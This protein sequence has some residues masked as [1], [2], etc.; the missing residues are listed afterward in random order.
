MSKI[1]NM[2]RPAWLIA[3]V[4]ITV[5]LVPAVAV[6][7]TGATILKGSPSGNKADVTPAGQLLSTTVDPSQFYQPF[8]AETYSGHQG[9]LEAPS[10]AALVITSIRVD[11]FQ[12]PT[13]GPTDTM[14]FQIEAGACA[15]TDVSPYG[16]VISPG[17]IG[18]TVL[19]LDPGLGIPAGDSLCVGSGGGIESYVT[20]SGYTVPSSEVTAGP[21]HPAASPRE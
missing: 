5:L 8:T 12:N 1:T 13:P 20:A 7:T 16:E 14:L 21:L 18:E 10:T 15:G 11:T 3:G 4:A 9:I 2:S 19:P 6:A 17:G